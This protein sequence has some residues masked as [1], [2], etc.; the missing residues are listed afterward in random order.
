MTR[1]ELSMGLRGLRTKIMDPASIPYEDLGPDEVLALKKV[2]N[3]ITK[4]NRKEDILPVAYL[5]AT[6]C[7]SWN[8]EEDELTLTEKGKEALEFYRSEQRNY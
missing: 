4:V 6:S 3:G 7:V 8:Q 5:I 2:G 1:E